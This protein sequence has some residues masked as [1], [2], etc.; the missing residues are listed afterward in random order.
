MKRP[1]TSAIRCEVSSETLKVTKSST[2]GG[3]ILISV[4]CIH[5]SLQV[6]LIPYKTFASSFSIVDDDD[7]LIDSDRLV[8]PLLD[9]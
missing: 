4:T 8:D 5:V 7:E 6:T 2:L 3:G 9:R 1:F